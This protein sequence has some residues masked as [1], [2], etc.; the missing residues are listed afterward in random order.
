ME[1]F[2]RIGVLY[3]APVIAVAVAIVYFVVL[4]RRVRRGSLDRSKA[5]LRYSTTLLLPPAVVIAVWAAGELSS[6]FAAASA[7]LAWDG[8]AS[9]QFLLS[10]LPLGAYVGIPIVALV[11][12]FWAVMAVSRRA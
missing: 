12:S 3:A 9:L 11:V 4:L 1:I 10:L 8:T 2:I 5:A 7:D 6:Y